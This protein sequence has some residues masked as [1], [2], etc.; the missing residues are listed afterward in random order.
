M[1]TL[2][3]DELMSNEIYFKLQQIAQ[4]N[5]FIVFKRQNKPDMVINVEILPI[6]HK[7]KFTTHAYG[8]VL[9]DCDLQMVVGYNYDTDLNRVLLL[10]A[11]IYAMTVWNLSNE[12]L[13]FISQSIKMSYDSL[14]HIHRSTLDVIQHQPQR[15]MQNG[16]FIQIVFNNGKYHIDISSYARYK[17]FVAEKVAIVAKNG[18][19]F[20]CETNSKILAEFVLHFVNACS[21]T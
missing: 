19:N 20:F 16:H 15:Y 1:I 7:I 6:P 5:D 11:K 8:T 18:T 3:A 12:D 10:G 13:D 2:Y 17:P 4:H 14:S 21:T 9:I